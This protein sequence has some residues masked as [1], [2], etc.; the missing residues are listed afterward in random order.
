M[1][2]SFADLTR[3]LTVDE[4]KAKIYAVLAAL[5][6][7]TT[8]WKTGAVVRTLIAGQSVFAASFTKLTANIAKSGF[9]ELSSGD[10]LKLVARYVYNVEF[11]PASYAAGEI[12]LVNAGGGIYPF[13]PDDLVFT[14]PITGKQFRNTGSG[15]LG[16]LATLTIPI[17]AIEA[18][19]ASTSSPG[20]VTELTT[21]LLG[22]TC[23][24]ALPLVGTDEE[25]DPSLRT[26]CLEKLGS[27]SPNGPWDAFS[28][29]ARNAKR[30]SDGTSVG[31]TRV[32]VTKDGYGRVTTYVATATGGLSGTIGDTT[33]DLGAVD[34]AIQ[35]R[36]APL[37]V[38]A[39]VYS[40]LAVAI[41]VTYTVWM[42]N[43]AGLTPAQLADLITA[44][45]TVY[46]ATQPV[47]GN[48]VGTDPGKVFV[49]AIRTV[50]GATRPEIFHVVVHTPAADVVL[51][52]QEVP[53]LG[54]T[55]PVA[56]NQVPG[57]EGTF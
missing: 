8:S 32:R 45:L 3:P 55:A 22:V 54:P 14:N 40:A 29:A 53:V 16:A 51:A 39:D 57:S 7:N 44:R 1:A 13:D 48:V 28:F 21:V 31:V 19:S 23:S 6:V 41:G 43:T 34:D 17:R 56:I 10:W 4:V 50:I 33:T 15:S 12:T 36:A 37:A 2:L 38:T 20:T 26:R 5:G 30:S 42:Y 9:L 46:M 52:A 25:S 47:G 11:E 24:N 35:R 27:L 49:D 18:G